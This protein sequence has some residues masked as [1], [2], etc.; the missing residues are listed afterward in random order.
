MRIMYMHAEMAYIKAVKWN[1]KL[2]GTPGAI[3]MTA[4]ISFKIVN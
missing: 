1:M 3:F 4:A 2:T